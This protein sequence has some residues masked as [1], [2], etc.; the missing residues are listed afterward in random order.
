[1]PR[2]GTSLIEQVIASHSKVHG[3][4]ETNTLYKILNKYFINDGRL[5]EL[6]NL[7]NKIFND[8]GKEYVTLMKNKSRNKKFIIDK[9]PINF[10]WIGLINIILPE[11]KIINCT[12]N[13]Y[14][15]C[16]SIFE[17]F[18]HI[19]GNEYTFNLKEI[20][21]YYNLYSD[22][23]NYWKKIIHKNF[24]EI[25]YEEF[26][27]NQKNNTKKL[28]EYCSLAWEDQCMNFHLT[29]RTVRTSSDNQ[30][31]QKIYTQSINKWKKYKDD[32]NDLMK[33]IDQH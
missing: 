28:L 13:P 17:N 32:L 24:F 18:F 4:G 33:I 19:R 15:T 3:A 22:L 6:N 2:S 5:L 10:R 26:I 9:L 16:L 31:R 8:A 23:L 29:K 14:D 12:R 20:A 27:Y 11:A 30:V 1:M 21:N 25:N 7:D